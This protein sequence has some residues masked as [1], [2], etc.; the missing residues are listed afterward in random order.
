MDLY[1]FHWL[2]GSKNEGFGRDAADALNA[3]GFGRG[4]LRALDFWEK[5]E[6]DTTAPVH[7]PDD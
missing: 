2:D 3:L 6:G 1:R 4:A 5:V 7:L